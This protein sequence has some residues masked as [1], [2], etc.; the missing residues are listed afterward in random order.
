MILQR[1]F[2]PIISMHLPVTC[3]RHGL[4]AAV[5]ALAATALSAA[6][7]F[8]GRVEMTLTNPGHDG[9]HVVSYAL[10][11]GKLRIDFLKNPSGRD[12]GGGSGGMIV[13]LAKH[14]MIIL[15]EMPDREGG[16]TRKMYMRRPMPQP[17]ET[18]PGGRPTE[19]GSISDPVATGRTEVIAGYTATEYK[20]TG[21]KGEVT[22]LWLAKGLGSFMFPGA[23]NPMGRGRLASASPAWER[24]VRDG[25]FFPLRVISR[26]AGGAE[27][28]RLEV[29]KIEKTSQPDA[30]FTPE[31]YTE[32][33]MPGFGGGLPG[34]LNPFKH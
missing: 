22:E 13:D 6:G 25:G 17:G 1:V 31:G 2:Q 15:M 30:L 7:S 21:K 26:D 33:Q 14:E 8:E 32:F 20:V 9:S 5:F 23:Q 28:M 18:P 29:T 11:E 16:G 10:K 12:N 27:D 24:L 34:G 4:V 19:A 3:L